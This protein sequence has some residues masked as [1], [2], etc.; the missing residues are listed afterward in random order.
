[1]TPQQHFTI[2]WQWGS[3]QLRVKVIICAM[4]NVQEGGVCHFWNPQ[5]SPWS[6]FCISY[7]SVPL[8]ACIQ[9][10]DVSDESNHSCII[11]ELQ[12]Q[13]GYL[14]EQSYV[15]R[16]KRTGLST[17]AWGKPVQRMM[18]VEET[19][20]IPTDCDLFVRKSR[21]KLHRVALCLSILSFCISLCSII[22]LK[23]EQKSSKNRWT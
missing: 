13:L 17:Q 6:C 1:M 23:A 7:P 11:C 20:W 9:T 21:T 5:S 15:S 12:R 2:L 19:S 22:V 3:V 4:T 18:R 10:S 8:P 14:A 16:A